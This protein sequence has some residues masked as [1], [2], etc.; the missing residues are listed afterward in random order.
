MQIVVLTGSRGID[1][2]VVVVSRPY[3]AK[4][5]GWIVALS[6]ARGGERWT[7]VGIP[8]RPWM[9][10]Y[11]LVAVPDID[12]DGWED[13]VFGQPGNVFGDQI[14]ACSGRTGERIWQVKGVR[15]GEWGC[16]G[17]LGE[18]LDGDGIR[19]LIV[20]GRSKGISTT[21]PHSSVSYVASKTGQVF[22][23]VMFD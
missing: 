14:V 4:M 22:W 3:S 18:D 1:D 11:M 20:G 7:I 12:G 5:S 19:D 21:T 15:V 8:E 2:P 17:C 9:I 6:G 23:R 13:V 10:G 16:S